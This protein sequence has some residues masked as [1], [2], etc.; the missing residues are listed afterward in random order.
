MNTSPQRRTLDTEATQ[1]TLRALEIGPAA[2][3]NEPV[4]PVLYPPED[5]MRPG[6]SIAASVALGAALW[7][8]VAVLVWLAV[9]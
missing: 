2:A 8:L 3:A 9:R 4:I 5:D 6:K 1:R 7:T